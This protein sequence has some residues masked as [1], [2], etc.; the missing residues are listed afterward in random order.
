MH[1]GDI[2]T[3]DNF[4]KQRAENLTDGIF[5]TVMTILILSLAVPVIISGNTNQ[6]LSTDIV[7]LLP[8]ILAYVM[9]F[10]VLGAIWIGHNNIFR[11]LERAERHVQWIN[12]LFLLS[13]GFIPFSTALLGRYPLQQDVGDGVWDQPICCHPDIQCILLIR[14]EGEA[15]S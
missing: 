1:K 15:G 5:A 10:I 6:L 13:V 3:I 11:Y 4:T 8:N 7:A 9:S 2:H 12:L 14:A